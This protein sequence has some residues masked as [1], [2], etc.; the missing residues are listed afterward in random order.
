MSEFELDPRIAGD[1][2]ALGDIG[3]IHVRGMVG[4]PWPWLVLIPRYPEAVELYDLP[5]MVASELQATTLRLARALKQAFVADKI[6]IAALGNVVSQLHV[7]IVARQVG[8]PGWPA[9]VWG[10][11]EAELSANQA[12]ERLLQLRNCLL[13]LDQIDRSMPGLARNAS[14]P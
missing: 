3:S 14:Q 2:V 12:E 8:D 4:A 5:E 7:H 13:P 9:P 10:R 11:N 6:N 1:S